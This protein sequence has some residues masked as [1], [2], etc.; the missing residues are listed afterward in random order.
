MWVTTLHIQVTPSDDCKGDPEDNSRAVSAIFGK[1]DSVGPRRVVIARRGRVD[2]SI[3]HDWE[4][5]KNQKGQPNEQDEC[6]CMDIMRVVTHLVPGT[7]TTAIER[8]V[9]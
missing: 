4:L 7:I 8:N 6:H 5:F 3:R 2:F 1:D 9:L